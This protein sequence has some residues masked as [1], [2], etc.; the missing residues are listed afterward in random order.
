MNKSI[1]YKQWLK[2]QSEFG[3]VV[4]SIYGLSLAYT[5]YGELRDVIVEDYSAPYNRTISPNAKLEFPDP[6]NPTSVSNNNAVGFKEEDKASMKKYKGYDNWFSAAFSMDPTVR[7][8]PNEYGTVTFAFSVR[9]RKNLGKY[10]HRYGYGILP[11]E[12]VAEDTQPP[13]SLSITRANGPDIQDNFPDSIVYEILDPSMI[14]NVYYIIFSPQSKEMIVTVVNEDGGVNEVDLGV[15]ASKLGAEPEGS[16]NNAI[17]LP[18]DDN[19][20][21]VLMNLLGNHSAIIM[22]DLENF[23]K[24]DVAWDASMLSGSDDL[25]FNDDSLEGIELSGF[26]FDPQPLLSV[27]GE[28][29][30]Q[31]ELSDIGSDFDSSDGDFDD[32]EFDVDTDSGEEDLE[33]DVDEEPEEEPEGEE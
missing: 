14:E 6:V 28:D 19:L 1:R 31:G 29:S 7:E 30:E 16:D 17:I 8:V 21:E 5:K 25:N 20:E 15:L 3:R 4:E 10:F 27:G 2:K 11:D 22:K 26:N 9:T 23:G 33:V 12:S 18:M 24:G 32:T 13:A